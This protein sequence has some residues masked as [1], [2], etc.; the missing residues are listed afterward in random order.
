MSEPIVGMSV[1]IEG[2]DEAVRGLDL[3]DEVLGSETERAI[4][5]LLVIAQGRLAV[6]P[7]AP[8]FKRTGQLGQMWV[9]ATH[10]IR[11]VQQAGGRFFVE[12]QISNARPGIEFVQSAAEQVPVH[13]GRWETTEQVAAL[14]QPE[15]DRLLGLA[16]ESAVGSV[17]K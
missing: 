17:G 5:R 13:Q 15:A 1:E 11:R 4:D 9:G 8:P 7:A 12:G 14:L 6:Y 3:M 16:G 2:L 10:Q